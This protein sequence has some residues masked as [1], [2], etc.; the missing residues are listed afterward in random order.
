[1]SGRDSFIAE[2]DAG[3]GAGAA[4]GIV[5]YAGWNGRTGEPH[6]TGTITAR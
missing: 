2:A 4:S 1:V 5:T 6:F 3:G